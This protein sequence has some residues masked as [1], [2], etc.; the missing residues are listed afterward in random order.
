MNIQLENKNIKKTKSLKFIKN[1]IKKKNINMYA[2]TKKQKEP[3]KI[4]VQTK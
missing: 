4:K 3:L 1:K 2:I